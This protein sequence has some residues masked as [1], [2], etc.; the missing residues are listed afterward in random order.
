MFS[1]H[2]YNALCQNSTQESYAR[3]PREDEGAMVQ[4]IQRALETYQR[5]FTQNVNSAD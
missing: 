4:A 2:L 1:D 5:L 3:A